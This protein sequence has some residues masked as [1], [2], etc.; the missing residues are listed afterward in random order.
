MGDF[1]VLNFDDS[2]QRTDTVTGGLDARTIVVHRDASLPAGAPA[3][4]T[5]VLHAVQNIEKLVGH[6]SLD[7]TMRYVQGTRQDLQ[8]AVETI[9]WI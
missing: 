6:D 1:Y 7:T 9:A 8:Q 5:E 2:T 3:A 4:L